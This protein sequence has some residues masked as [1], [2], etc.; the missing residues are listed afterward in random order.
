M[1]QISS[2][3]LDWDAVEASSVLDRFYLVR[4][5]LP[6]QALIEALEAKR[7]QGWDDYPVKAM[8]N[9]VLAGVVFQ[10][11]SIE[12]LI[13]ELSRNPAL[14]QACGFDVLPVQR[15]PV[16]ETVRDELTG[17]VLIHCPD[18]EPP[19]YAVPRGWNFSHFLNNLI[20]LETAQGLVSEM[21]LDLRRQLMAVLPDFG[22]HLGYDGKAIASHSTGQKD[23]QT[24]Q[25]SDPD[26]DWGKHETVGID[27][28][29]GKPWKKV[30][31]WFGY[32]L[33]LIADT[34]YEIPVAFHLTPVSHSETVEC[35]QML[36]ELFNEAPE[37]AHR[38]EDFSADRGA[39]LRENQIPV[40]G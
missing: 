10:H 25:Y 37:L 4:D 34:H 27:G 36:V 5:H 30:K 20:E 29:T 9:A 18:P 8:W 14:L 21:I 23:K 1:A 38:C 22:Q 3:L 12:S 32:G 2:P 15:K 35:R 28:R 17:R 7:G 33:H 13:R 40:M 19:H 26:A 16:A 6:D 11:P 39:G 31:S 24:G